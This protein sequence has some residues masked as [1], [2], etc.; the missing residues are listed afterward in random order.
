[1]QQNVTW[2]KI[3]EGL[4][5][6]FETY[7]IF[8]DQHEIVWAVFKMREECFDKK[9]Q[10]QTNIK[11][12]KLKKRCTNFM[13]Q[14]V[15]S[16]PHFVT[17]WNDVSN[18]YMFLDHFPFSVVK[19]YLVQTQVTLGDKSLSWVVWPQWKEVW[20]WIILSLC[21]LLYFFFLSF[22]LFYLLFTIIIY[23]YFY[24]IFNFLSILII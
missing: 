14:T 21:G 3:I 18:K 9:Q 13:G 1:M 11:G 7:Y 6:G 8:Q 4:E 19:L 15:G 24:F 22:F 20:L 23:F 2:V 5:G 12:K 10:K 17:I 16:Y